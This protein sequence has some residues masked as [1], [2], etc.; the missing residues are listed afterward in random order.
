LP[1]ET[2]ERLR[3]LQNKLIKEC[4]GKVAW[5]KVDNIHLTLKFLGEIGEDSVKQ[6]MATLK[7]VASRYQ[8][9]DLTVT[10]LDCFPGI[11]NPRVVWAG[12]ACSG[13]ELHTLQKDVDESLV[14]HSFIKDKRKFNAHLTLGRIKYLKEK[15]KWKGIVENFRDVEIGTLTVDKI[16]FFQSTL[17]PAGAVYSVLG[18]AFL[19]RS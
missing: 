16:I 14:K 12:I 6:I 10:G 5:V 8:P 4:P 19:G 13:E 3:S 7:D 11:E 15:M 17:K 2:R 1:S 9:F 18:E